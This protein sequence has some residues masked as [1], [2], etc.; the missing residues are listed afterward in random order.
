MFRKKGKSKTF[1]ADLQLLLSLKKYPACKIN[2]TLLIFLTYLEF[3]LRRNY[4]GFL[5]HLY[6][7]TQLF[8]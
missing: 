6:F 5:Q 7:E 4:L 8:Q 1:S 2:A 3:D